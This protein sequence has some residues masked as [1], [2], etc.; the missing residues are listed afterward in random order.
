[1]RTV[2]QLTPVRDYD[3]GGLFVQ[4]VWWLPPAFHAL[5]MVLRVQ[6][7]AELAAEVTS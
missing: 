1:M 7:L 6:T 2:T 3:S 4:R 5:V